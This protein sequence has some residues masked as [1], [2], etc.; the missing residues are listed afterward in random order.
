MA[1]YSNFVGVLFIGWL[2]WEKMKTIKVT[3]RPINQCFSLFLRKKHILLHSNHNS[4]IMKPL[5]VFLLLSFSIPTFSQISFFK[6]IND[7]EEGSYPANFTE[8]KGEVYFSIQTIDGNRLWKTNGTEGGTVQVSDLTILNQV[9]NGEKINFSNKLISVC[10]NELY[11]ATFKFLPNYSVE[12]WKTDGISIQKVD[13]LNSIPEFGL[14]NSLIFP[15][16]NNYYPHK[17]QILNNHLINFKVVS[18]INSDRNNL[19]IW[20]N[21]GLVAGNTL[22]DKVDSVFFWVS[23]GVFI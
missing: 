18:A 20:K 6:Q 17:R 15:E 2:Y 16:Y 21:N 14:N 13:G 23:K 1:I 7:V 10:N 3:S 22:I 11:F 9:S 8:F 12:I 5:I 19:E 4:H